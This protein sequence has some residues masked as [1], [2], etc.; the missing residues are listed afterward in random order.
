M[1]RNKPL[2]IT[3]VLRLFRLRRVGALLA[4]SFLILLI[5]SQE[6]PSS[7]TQS[8]E[9]IRAIKR[10]CVEDFEGGENA[11]QLR[12]MLIDQLRRLD[13]FVITE[14]PKTADAFLRGFA[15]DLVYTE[16]HSRDESIS[17][18]SGGSLSSGG[19]NSRDRRAISLNSGVS[20][21]VRE[22][23][24]E[25]RHEASL[26]VRIVNVHGD[27]LWSAIAESRGGKY[28]SAAADA[29]AKIAADL[30]K[31]MQPGNGSPGSARRKSMSKDSA[32]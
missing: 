19:P 27:V 2:D 11:R 3:A 18:R 4:A 12:A 17:G 28:R 32:D 6:L 16:Q 30:R 13:A 26:S 5:S 9:H 14:N 24:T 20:D 22:R 10:L 21:S 31:A 7:S 25:R 8:V 1:G 29:S 15:E 23:S